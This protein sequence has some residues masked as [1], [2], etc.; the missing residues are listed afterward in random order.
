MDCNW[1]GLCETGV[2]V[3]N[4]FLCLRVLTFVCIAALPV[5]R[6]GAHGTS[7]GVSVVDNRLTIGNGIPDSGGYARMMFA[8]GDDD[9]DPFGSLTLSG[10]GPATIWQIPGFDISGLDEHSG[11]F[12]DVISRPVSTSNPT[13]YRSLWYWNPSTQRVATTPAAN[14]FQIRKSTSVNVTLSPTSSADPPALQIAEPLASDMGFDKHLLA[15]ALSESS[16]SPSGAYGFFARLTSN[17]YGASD[18]F[19]VVINNGVDYAQMIPAARAIN[20]AAFLPGDYNHDDRVDAADYNIWRKTFGSS[21]ELAADGSGNQLID[22]PDFDVW[23]RNFGT[24]VSSGGSGVS[25]T[26]VPEPDGW[27]VAAIGIICLFAGAKRGPSL[28]RKSR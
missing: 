23:R 2:K 16:P 9:G 10:F 24:S 14:P 11:L 4:R 18:P 8:E 27:V 17:Q 19:L 5:L 15:Y 12:L 6:V 28:P 1:D 7:I 25:L 13:E 26:S 21:M 22:L 3:R 20:A